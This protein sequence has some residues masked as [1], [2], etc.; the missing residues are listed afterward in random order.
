M[1]SCASNSGHVPSTIGASSTFQ[2]CAKSRQ[3]DPPS[4]HGPTVYTAG[5]VPAGVCT[6]GF[7]T[8]AALYTGNLVRTGL[9]T[10]VD[11][12]TAQTP[13]GTAP[14][15]H[16]AP[17]HLSPQCANP[18]RNDPSSAHGPSSPPSTAL[19][20]RIERLARPPRNHALQRRQR[21]GLTET[22]RQATVPRH[23][24]VPLLFKWGNPLV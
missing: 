6:Q 8:P 23:Q 13:C 4:A 3:N 5:V 14:P 20:R 24:G 22:M 9:C 18:S 16:T 12:G 17:P 15:V 10:L 11:A 7:S 19:Q 2:Q 1:L 21:R